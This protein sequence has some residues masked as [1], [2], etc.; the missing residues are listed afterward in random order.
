MSQMKLVDMHC[1]TLGVLLHASEAD[2]GGHPIPK[3][4]GPVSMC[5]NPFHISLEKL[6]KGNYLLQNRYV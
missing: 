2:F 4:D 1:D 6:Q 5:Q 3:T